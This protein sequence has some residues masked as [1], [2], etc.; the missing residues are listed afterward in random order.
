MTQLQIIAR[1]DIAEQPKN[2]HIRL[3]DLN[4]DGRLEIV[5]LQPDVCA[6][7]RYFPRQINYAAAFNLD[8]EMLWQFGSPDYEADYTADCN[9]PAQIFDIDN[10]GSNE[11]LIVSGGEMLYIDGMTGQPKKRFPLPAPDAHDAIIIADLEGKGYPQNIIL[12]NKYHQLWAMDANF[13]VIWTYK[14]N[15]GNYPWPYDVN[16]DGE[17][18][19]IAGFN[20]LNGDGE[21]IGSISNESGYAKYTWVGDLYRRGDQKKAIAVLGDK[22]TA[23][24]TDGEILWQNNISADDAAFGNLSSVINGTE[25]C[26]TSNATVMLDCYGAKVAESDIKN[27][28]LTSVH[29]LDESGGDMLILHSG[30]SP[31]MLLDSELNPLYTFPNCNKV[32]WA[33]IMGDGIADI[34]LLCDD[35]IEIYSA[36]Q[37]DLSAPSVPYSRPQPKRLYNYTDYASEMEPSQYALSYVTGSL[38]EIDLEQWATNCALGNDIASDDAISR[39]DFIVLLVE[40]LGLKAYERDNFTDVSIKDYFFAAVGTAKKLG[41]IEGTL[42]RFNPNLPMTAEAAVE[43]IKKAGHNCFC[44][45]EGELTRRHAARIV[46]ELLLR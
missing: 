2:C 12:K 13:N 21:V 14:G 27:G 19:L 22:L 36:K 3:G 20:I 25:V 46:L 24:T 26:Y 33:D 29:N 39:A 1:I 16:D 11:L 38:S 23:L 32:I 40:A 31:A 10:D 7:D 4:S 44:M 30:N 35:R 9:I 15:I 42:G 43:I 45:T 18:E 34:V 17:D 41:I 37:K 5:I 8:G 28:K 6:D